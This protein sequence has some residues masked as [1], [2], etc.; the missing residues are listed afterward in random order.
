[1]FLLVCAAFAQEPATIVMPPTVL[2]VPP[3]APQV[4]VITPRQSPVIEV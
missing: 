3:P 4:T 1:M 2:E